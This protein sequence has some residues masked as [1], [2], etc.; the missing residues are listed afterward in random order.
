MGLMKMQSEQ[1]FQIKE[2]KVG[3][4]STEMRDIILYLCG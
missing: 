2:V 3:R 4:E 1:G